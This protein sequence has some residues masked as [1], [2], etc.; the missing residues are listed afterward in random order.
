MENLI[1][2]LDEELNYSL[3]QSRSRINALIRETGKEKKKVRK[4]H[5][6]IISI[7]VTWCSLCVQQK[8]LEKKWAFQIPP[9]TLDLK[10]LQMQ[11]SDADEERR[12]VIHEQ[13]TAMERWVELVCASHTHTRPVT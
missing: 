8:D 11:F 6:M 2:M 13:L 5:T 3:K 4:L 7:H 9:V 10:D 1:T 12:M